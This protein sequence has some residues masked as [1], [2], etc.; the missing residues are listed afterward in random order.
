MPVVTSGAT[1][2]G[3]VQISG[4]SPTATPIESWLNGC[5]QGK[6]Y[7]SYAAPT[8]VGAQS[9]YAELRNPSGSGKNLWIYNITAA[10]GATSAIYLTFNTPPVLGAGSHGV[11][12]QTGLS[13]SV[14]MLATSS[15]ASTVGTIFGLFT[16]PANQTLTAGQP[17]LMVLAPN[18]SVI[19]F[20]QI[21]NTALQASIYWMEV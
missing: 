12:L 14:A 20:G 2:V 17:W 18:T 15:S 8:P 11:N 21:V 9:S 1:T 10:M 13:N 16:V 3:A 19:V 4:L 5:L 7:A 6:S